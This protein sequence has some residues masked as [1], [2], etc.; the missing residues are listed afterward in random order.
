MYELEE[1]PCT[2]IDFEFAPDSIVY[3]VPPVT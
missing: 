2:Y 3:A 1:G